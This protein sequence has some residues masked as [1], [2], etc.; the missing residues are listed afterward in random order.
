LHITPSFNIDR[1]CKT[2][3]VLLFLVP[4]LN[5][6]TV[7]AITQVRTRVTNVNKQTTP[8][9]H[10]GAVGRHRKEVSLSE[11]LPV[12]QHFAGRDIRQAINPANHV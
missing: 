4:Y 8:Q 6:V 11:F 1:L 2:A 10:N 7:P 9:I 12:G 3:S 5:K